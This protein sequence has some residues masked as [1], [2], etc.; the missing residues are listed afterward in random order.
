MRAQMEGG[1]IE[2]PN[3]PGKGLLFSNVKE[4]GRGILNLG[5]EVDPGG[6]GLGDGTPMSIDPYQKS[7]GQK[8]WRDNR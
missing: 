1:G 8:S 4:G 2:K 3:E 6:G 5:T 7:G